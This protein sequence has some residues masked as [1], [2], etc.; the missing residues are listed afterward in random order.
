LWGSLVL[1]CWPLVAADV[2]SDAD[3][4]LTVR[5]ERKEFTNSIGMRFVPVLAGTFLMGSPKDEERREQSGQGT[6]EPHEVEISRD[7][8]LCVHEV[9]QK[10]YKA[11]MGYNPSF[12]S[13]D[14]KPAPK[15]KY[16]STEPAEGKDNVKGL[17]TSDFPVENVSWE[18]ALEFLTKLN[19]LAAERKFRVTYRLPTEAEWEYACRGGHLIKDK[20]KA[21]LPFHFRAPCASLGFGQANFASECPYGGGKVGKSPGRT[22]TVGNNGEANDLGLYDMHG[23]ACEWCSDWYDPG[24]FANSPRKDPT[25]PLRGSYRVN[26]GGCWCSRGEYC[27]AAD[28]S[29]GEPS[30][31]HY[32][33]GFRVAAVP[34][35]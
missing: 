15:G 7:F 14:G 35:Q 24:Y 16:S 6:E 2:P 5:V 11:V 13:K 23:N 32:A 30:R 8:Y 29:C 4:D 3:V 21:Q 18:D 9:T 28:R 17:D 33:V 1:L 34:R 25:G 22:N 20:K 26:R 27:R 10:Q 12:F 31:R 19:A